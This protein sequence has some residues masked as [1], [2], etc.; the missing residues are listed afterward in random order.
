[1][2]LPLTLLAG[3]S[4]M[5]GLAPAAYGDPATS[6]DE[7]AFLASLH[8]AGITYTTPEAA[9]KFAKSVCQS[10]GNGEF[11]PQMLDELKNQNP[12]LTTEHASSFL[13][14]AV[15]YYCPQQLNH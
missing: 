9:I 10:M 3:V 6:G 15:K 7:A 1:M 4:A 2:R 13:A 8:S 5:I 12:G 14:I 11:G